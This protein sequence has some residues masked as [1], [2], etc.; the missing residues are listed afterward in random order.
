[1]QRLAFP[2]RRALR[3]LTAA[4]IFS[5]CG[6]AV[7]VAVG[8]DESAQGESGQWDSSPISDV[9]SPAQVSGSDLRVIPPTPFP[10]E[11]IGIPLQ[12]EQC[13]KPEVAM[14]AAPEVRL[15]NKWEFDDP[16]E[17]HY[18]YEL[19]YQ[20]EIRSV[21][22]VGVPPPSPVVFAIIGDLP[23]GRHEFAIT[24]LFE[25]E[26]YLSYSKMFRVDADAYPRLDMSGAWHAPSQSGRGFSVMQGSGDFLGVYWVTHDAEGQP[27]W[28]LLATSERSG[29]RYSG[30][31]VRTSGDAFGAEPAKLEQEVW[32][33]AS[34]IH[35]GCGRA[36]WSWE[37]LDPNTPSGELELH[38][39]M[40]PAGIASCRPEDHGKTITAEWVEE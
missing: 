4:A 38:Q 26:T 5:V 13:G 27:T 29:S 34:F 24:G 18:S 19:V 32:G 15:V 7:A 31:L 21:L 16:R 9:V 6:Q 33:H 14:D 11:K 23:V 10:G 12:G 25:G 35:T 39:I 36:L 37:A 20:L 2:G 3:I 8:V 40:R 17:N 1:M 22:C 28:L 30:P